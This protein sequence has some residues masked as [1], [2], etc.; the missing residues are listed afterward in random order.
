MHRPTALLTL[1]LFA[2]LPAQASE[3]LRLPAQPETSSWQARVQ[4]LSS[5]EIGGSHLVGANLLGDYYFGR[6][7][8][9]LRL[10][11]GLLYG[12]MA[13]LGSGAGLALG[14]DAVSLGQRSLRLAPGDSNL[15]Q[16]YLGVGYSSQGAAWRFSAD[17]GVAMRGDGSGLSL[18]TDPQD[19]SWRGMQL[20]PMVQ[21]G[22]SYRF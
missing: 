1:T 20:T 2:A 13:L 10:S 6:R 16:P 17:V 14:P 4:L 11:G 15:R 22:L 3:G 5:E 9:G 12:P 7:N 8:G 21:M 18:R 19:L